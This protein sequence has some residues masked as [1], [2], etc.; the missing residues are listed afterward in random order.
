MLQCPTVPCLLFFINASLPLIPLPDC[1]RRK[2][3]PSPSFLLFDF[4]LS[5]FFLYYCFYWSF[6]YIPFSTFERSKDRVILSISLSLSVFTSE[7]STPIS[8]SSYFSFS[9]CVFYPLFFLPSSSYPT[10]SLGGKSNRFLLE[11]EELDLEV[12]V[13]MSV[14]LCT[15]VLRNVLTQAMWTMNEKDKAWRE[16]RERLLRRK[17]DRGTKVNQEKI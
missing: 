2:V 14:Y 11:E 13:G 15:H 4:L 16:V 6:S 1:D 7:D 8:H 9:L 10:P 5:S 17:T 12:P 3:I